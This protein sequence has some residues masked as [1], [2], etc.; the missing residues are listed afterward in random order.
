MESKHKNALIGALLAVVFVMAV[1]YAAF[2][3]T[4]TI[5]GSASISSNWDVHYNRDTDKYSCTAT[6]TG[7][8]VTPTATVQFS[9][10]Y[11]ASISASLQSPGDVLECTL[12]IRNYGDID[13]EIASITLSPNNGSGS[14]SGLT[15]TSTSQNITFVVQDITGTQLNAGNETTIRVTISFAQ[16]AGTVSQETASV[17]VSIN[18]EQA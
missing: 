6:S 17:D 4:L 15:F 12:T 8:T 14:V 18:A 3:Q 11:T 2:A 16:T 5:N 10:D 9:D 1:G 7:G 13:A